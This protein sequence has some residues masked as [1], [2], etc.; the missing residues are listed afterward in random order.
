MHTDKIALSVQEAAAL[1]GVS[2]STMYEI[3]NRSDC[4]FALHIGTR[5]LISRPKLEQ[6]ITRQTEEARQ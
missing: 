5:R 6:W 2:R 3:M 4:D 1:I